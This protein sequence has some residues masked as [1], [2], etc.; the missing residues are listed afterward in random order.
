MHEI[1]RA[2]KAMSAK[3]QGT[4]DHSLIPPLSNSINCDSVG[5]TVILPPL[6]LG[7]KIANLALCI[8]STTDHTMQ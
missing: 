7:K 2:E 1:K 8:M 4:T 5:M 3:I 6:R